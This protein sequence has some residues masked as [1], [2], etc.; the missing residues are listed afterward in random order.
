MQQAEGH[1]LH[2]YLIGDG[3]KEAGGDLGAVKP[4]YHLQ[5]SFLGEIPPTRLAPL[6]HVLHHLELFLYKADVQTEGLH[7][8]AVENTPGNLGEIR[9]VPDRSSVNPHRTIGVRTVGE[10]PRIRRGGT[11]FLCFRLRHGTGIQR[12]VRAVKAVFLLLTVN[13]IIITTGITLLYGLSLRTETV[14][15]GGFKLFFQFYILP[16]QGFTRF[17]FFLKKGLQLIQFFQHPVGTG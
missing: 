13:R 16:F 8:L 2:V 7:Q 3:L 6:L 1:V 17:A 15:A 4:G 14:L 11:G 9:Q 10:I 5:V 12:F